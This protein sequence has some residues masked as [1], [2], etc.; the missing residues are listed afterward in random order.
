MPNPFLLPIHSSLLRW[1]LDK[2]QPRRYCRL[3]PAASC[4]FEVQWTTDFWL[5][6]WDVSCKLYCI[7]IQLTNVYLILR[8]STKS[9]I[10]AFQLDQFR[11]RSFLHKAI[12]LPYNYYLLNITSCLYMHSAFKYRFWPIPNE[13]NYTTSET[14]SLSCR[15]NW[16]SHNDHL[17]VQVLYLRGFLTLVSRSSSIL[18]KPLS[19]L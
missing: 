18:W 15:S 13:Y 1:W 8:I 16:P 9:V 12:P 14:W 10:F 19:P 11:P 4:G 17:T 2:H 5:S 6:T 7:V 3:W